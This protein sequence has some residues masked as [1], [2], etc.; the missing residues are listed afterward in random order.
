LTV[1]IS[2]K[3]QQLALRPAERIRR[4]LFSHINLYSIG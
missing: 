3:N 2:A 4:G 1:D